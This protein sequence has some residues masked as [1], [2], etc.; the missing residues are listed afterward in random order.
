[1]IPLVEQLCQN[2][3]EWE[4]YRVQMAAAQSLSSIVWIALQMGLF[5]ARQ[6]VQQE[7]ERRAAQ[8]TDW[9]NCVQCGRRLQSK[10]WQGRS[11]QTLVGKI[12]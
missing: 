5:M 2:Q 9:G 1:M 12:D 3:P 10:G 4:Q 11:L 7:L 6:L 8:P